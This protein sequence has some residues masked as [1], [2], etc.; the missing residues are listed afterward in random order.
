MGHVSAVKAQSTIQPESQAKGWNTL[1]FS[2]K[3]W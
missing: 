2:V 1:Q 3:G